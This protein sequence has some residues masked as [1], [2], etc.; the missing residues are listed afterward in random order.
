MPELPE[1]ETV[2]QGLIPVMNDK[3]ILKVDQLRPDLRYPLPRNMPSRLENSKILNVMRRSKYLL[4]DLSSL[5]TLIIHLGMSG[6]LMA[7]GVANQGR[8]SSS[9]LNCSTQKRN[10][11]DHIIIHLDSGIKIVYNDPRR[12]GAMDIIETK[13][14]YKHKWLK[15]LG[16]EPFSN[17]FSS[18][19]LY[20]KLQNRKSAIKTAL[21]DQAVVAGLGNI[22]AL[23]ALW[24]SRISPLRPS[25]T[26]HQ[27][28]VESLSA[29]ITNVLRLA[30]NAGGTSVQN[31]RQVG[32]EIGYFQHNLKA[33][34]CFGEKCKN[35]NCLG[36]I[37]RMKQA[38]RTSYYC[39]SCQK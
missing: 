31:F 37:K 5:E 28:E 21:L 20:E 3:T 26:I 25:N 13:K 4:F 24:L 8:N 19:Y 38:G 27:T 36:T 18:H 23:E 10:K 1:V 12:F 30:I 17:D 29:A 2:R 14:I 34:N 6:R 32:G 11:H 22:Y 15:N 16:P 7:I 33:Y 9:N 39:D 35:L